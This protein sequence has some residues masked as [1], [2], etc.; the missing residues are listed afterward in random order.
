M[1][2]IPMIRDAMR[3]SNYIDKNNNKN[4]DDDIIIVIITII[5]KKT[6]N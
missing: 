2:I 3:N 5:I 4:N 1:V 6:I